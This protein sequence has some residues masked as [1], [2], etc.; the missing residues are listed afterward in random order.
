[1]VLR[2]VVGAVVGVVVG[3]GF[4]LSLDVLP[5]RCDGLPG[6]PGCAVVAGMA[7]PVLFAFWMF[8]A[9]ALLWAGLR[10]ERSWQAT[11]IG[12]G[13]W[14]VLIVAAV[15]VEDFYLDL[16]QEDGRQ[17]RLAAAVI[18]PCFAYAVAALSTR[19]KT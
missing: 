13:L 18:V 10:K 3:A 6:G 4:L 12:G 14:L 17:F 11:G 19:N 15:L 5:S 7:L 2:T 1:M 9:G 16:L 8:V